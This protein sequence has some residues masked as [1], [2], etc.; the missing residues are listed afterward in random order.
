MSSMGANNNQFD[1]PVCNSF[2]AKI[3]NDQLCYEVDLNRFADKDNIERELKSGFYFLMD[4]NED[5]QITFD[6]NLSN[7]IEIGLANTITESNQD[8]HAIIYLNTIGQDFSL[9]IYKFSESFIVPEPVILLGEGQ[10]NLDVLTEVKATDSY[11]G[12]GQD[13]RECQNEEPYYNCTTRQ[14]ID[15][16]LAQ[17]GCLPLSIKFAIKVKLNTI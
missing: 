3:L 6:R 15:T 8:Q 7:K 2:E 12:L 9:Y 16:F 17:C 10:Y 14:Y 4:Y 1:I 5:R 13:V 11:L